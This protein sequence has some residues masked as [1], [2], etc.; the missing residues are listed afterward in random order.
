MEKVDTK[1][2]VAA[3]CAVVIGQAE[4]T[5][6]D[7]GIFLDEAITFACLIQGFASTHHHYYYHYLLM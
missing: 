2:L 3:S 1:L 6:D 7:L 4:Q 5:L